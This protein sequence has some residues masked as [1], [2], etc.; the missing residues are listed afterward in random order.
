MAAAADPHPSDHRLGHNG[1]LDYPSLQSELCISLGDNS[2]SVMAETKGH[3]TLR[4]HLQ[5]A[6]RVTLAR[7]KW[8]RGALM[9]CRKEFILSPNVLFRRFVL[10]SLVLIVRVLDESACMF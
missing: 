8:L 4:K 10:F 1:R 6:R 9:G 2:E 7:H 3:Q 5:A